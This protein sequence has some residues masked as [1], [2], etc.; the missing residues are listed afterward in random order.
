MSKQAL[1]KNHT[2]TNKNRQ[3]AHVDNTIDIFF[4]M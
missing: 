3:K 4:I 2:K 1:V